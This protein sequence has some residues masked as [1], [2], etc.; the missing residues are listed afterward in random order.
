MIEA[1]RSLGL[2][3]RFVSGYLYVPSADGPT[4]VGGGAT[5]AWVQIYLP[6][7]GW[8]EFDPTNGIVGNRDLIGRRGARPGASR[9]RLGYVD[10][11]AC[12]LPGND[13]RGERHHARRQGR[14]SKRQPDCGDGSKGFPL[15]SGRYRQL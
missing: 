9:A 15:T 2:A 8:I 12:R 4:N 6:G 7:A 14:S 5:H 3:A 10:R 1:A 11:G 13:R